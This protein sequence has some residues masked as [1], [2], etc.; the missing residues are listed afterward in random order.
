MMQPAP[1]GAPEQPQAQGGPAALISDLQ[2]GMK[3]L[4]A[5]LEKAGM[6]SEKLAQSIAMFEEAMD[7]VMGGG[8]EASAPEASASVEAGSNPNARPM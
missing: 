7:E 6:P 5:L 4:G 1:Q 2:G 8:G 3:K